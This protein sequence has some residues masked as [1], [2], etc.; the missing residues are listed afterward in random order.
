LNFN[1]FLQ[2]FSEFWHLW[3]GHFKINTM[4]EQEQDCSAAVLRAAC[5]TA[6]ENEVYVHALLGLLLLLE[7]SAF[8]FFLFCHTFSAKVSPSSSSSLLLFSRLPNRRTLPFR[9]PQTAGL[10]F[11]IGTPER[12][13]NIV[14][15][16]HT[17][18]YF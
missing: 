17:Y 4:L 14:R 15:V 13:S 6:A 9:H 10:L 2:C 7:E 1:G 16:R 12:L 3:W 5:S 18:S 8:R 11:S